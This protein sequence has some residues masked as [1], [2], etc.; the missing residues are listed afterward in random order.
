MYLPPKAKSKYP[1]VSAPLFTKL[2][3]SKS[4]FFLK[5]TQEIW[6]WHKFNYLSFW[7]VPLGSLI[8]LQQITKWSD[9]ETLSYRKS[10]WIKN[11]Y[12]SQVRQVVRAISLNTLRIIPIF[13][14]RYHVLSNY[15]N[16]L[17]PLGSL[18]RLVRPDL[19][20]FGVLSLLAHF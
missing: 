16:Q 12:S 18:D 13:I 10:L 15:V 11:I 2:L 8:C 19:T 9:S 1:S 17:G 6:V 3:F 14:T 4:V 5:S 20:C 7:N